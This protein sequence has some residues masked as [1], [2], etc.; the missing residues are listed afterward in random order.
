[1]ADNF[2]HGSTTE[3]K[4]VAK[5]AA[6]NVAAVTEQLLGEGSGQAVFFLQ[7]GLGAGIKGPLGGERR[8]GSDADEEE[9]EGE[10]GEDDGDGG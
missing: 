6:E 9:A 10:N 4:G 3:F 2:G 1:M 8:A 7:H 5:V